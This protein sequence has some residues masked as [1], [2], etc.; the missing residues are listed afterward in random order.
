MAIFSFFEE[1]D[2]QKPLME[3]IFHSR[4]ELIVSPK[5][6]LGRAI[7]DALGQK[8]NFLNVYRDRR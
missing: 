5:F 4:E 8:E 3:A 6:A 7:N 2:K 1:I